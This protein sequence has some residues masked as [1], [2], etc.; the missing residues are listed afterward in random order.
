[1]TAAETRALTNA[2]QGETHLDY[3]MRTKVYPAIQSMAGLGCDHA[4][5]PNCTGARSGPF[6]RLFPEDLS[7]KVAAVLTAQGY[8]ARG[9]VDRDLGP[10]VEVSW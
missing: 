2:R 10:T 4:R 6:G 3:L 5:V 7:A 9:Y 8:K 1:M